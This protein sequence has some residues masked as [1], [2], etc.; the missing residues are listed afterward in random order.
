MCRFIKGNNERTIPRQTVAQCKKVDE[1]LLCGDFSYYSSFPPSLSPCQLI[2][3]IWLRQLGV[4]LPERNYVRHLI[5]GFFIGR[6]MFP[7]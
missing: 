2:S 3:S 4:G 6:E 1:P 7:I 5:R